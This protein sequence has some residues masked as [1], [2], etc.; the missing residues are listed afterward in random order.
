MTVTRAPWVLLSLTTGGLCIAPVAAGALPDSGAPL[1]RLSPSPEVMAAQ[2]GDAGDW[3]DAGCARAKLGDHNTAFADLE[4]ASSA[5]FADRPRMAADPDLQNLHSDPRWPA[6]LDR[7]A[8]AGGALDHFWHSPVF[9]TPY[10]PALSE[11]E[12]IMG[13][14]R[15]WAEA[16]FNFIHF[17]KLPGLDWDEVYREFLP[18][19]RAAPDTLS[20]Y[21]LLEEMYAR[22]H[23]GHTGV[24]VPKELVPR[25]ASRPPVVPQL[26]DGKAIVVQVAGEAAAKRI[27][28]GSEI[29]GVD[30]ASVA[31]YTRDRVIPY[32][33]T[34]TDLDLRQRAYGNW[35]LRG[36]I[37]Q[38]VSLTLRYPDDH[39][40]QTSLARLSPASYS[41]MFNRPPMSFTML[42]G[43]IAYVMLNSFETAVTADMY[44]K[45]FPQIAK[46]RAIIFDVRYNGGGDTGVGYRVLATLT[47]HPFMSSGWYTRDYRPAYRAWRRSE[48]TAGGAPQAQQINPTLQFSGPVVVLTSPATFSAAEDFVAAFKSMRRGKLIGQPT[49]GSTGQ[50]LAFDLPGGGAARVC[51][52]HDSAPD[53]TEFVGIGLQPDIP[54]AP[55]VSAAAAGR[56]HV[57]EVATH[58]LSQGQ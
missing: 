1:S 52:K 17:D 35:L 49:G 30:G 36:D 11:D 39:I 57:L 6:L 47:T 28:L 32:L 54:A 29:L 44:E 18:R 27:P 15:A 9:S 20:Y 38:P 31:Q 25:I 55:S 56:D 45:A 24:S 13:L 40:H 33:G 58:Y 46:A 37:A 10:K 3:Y 2:S 51:T 22:L 16:K 8:R 26:I 42:P 41:A 4:R 5:G 7:V 43:G 14:S 23:D 19:V 48:G 53:G 34:S 12:K 21:L 50:P